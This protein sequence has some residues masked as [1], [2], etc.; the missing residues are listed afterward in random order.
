[1]GTLTYPPLRY[2]QTPLHQIR[3]AHA[4]G[5]SVL[6]F[7]DAME[8]WRFSVARIKAN[9]FYFNILVLLCHCFIAV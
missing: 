3:T 8:T 4:R 6:L 7:S 5:V 9:A 2:R 1:V